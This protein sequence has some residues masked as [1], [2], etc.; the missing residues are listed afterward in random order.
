MFCKVL[1]PYINIEG[2]AII[3][4]PTNIMIIITE[5]LVMSNFILGIGKLK[6]FYISLEKY[7]VLTTNNMV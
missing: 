1:T 2:N 4:S 6:Y 5:N 7:N 3:A